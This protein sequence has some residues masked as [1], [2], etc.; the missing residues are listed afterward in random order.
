MDQMDLH[1]I[2]L[3]TYAMRENMSMEELSALEQPDVYIVWKAKVLK[4]WKYVLSTSRADGRY[5]EATYNGEKQ[6]WYLDIYE[7]VSNTC[8]PVG[9]K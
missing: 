1:A 8:I 6:E 2:N 4:N 3:V 9:K 7:K 5:Y